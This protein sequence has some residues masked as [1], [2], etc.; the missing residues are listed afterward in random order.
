MQADEPLARRLVEALGDVPN[1][2]ARG[3]RRQDGC[4]FGGGSDFVEE[5]LLD[6]EAFDDRL[7]DEV[8]LR[9]SPFE[10]VVE[11]ARRDP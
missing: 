11:V 6:V 2:N 8:G 10:V 3:I 7:D 1:G 4:V 9:D 5:A